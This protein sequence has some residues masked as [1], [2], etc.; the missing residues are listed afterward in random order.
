[1]SGYM[2]GGEI[3]DSLRG[4]GLSF[5]LKGGSFL[6]RPKNKVTP[7][8]LLL[9]KDKKPL[10]L[11]ALKTEANHLITD[12]SELSEYHTRAPG[13]ILLGWMIATKINTSGCCYVDGCGGLIEFKGGQGICPLC[14]TLNTIAHPTG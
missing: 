5:E 9:L 7:D 14:G 6:V 13:E 12:E 10:I 11:A 4:N 2:S 1:M 3:L 8:I